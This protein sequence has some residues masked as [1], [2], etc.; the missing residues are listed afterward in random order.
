MEE[1]VTILLLV[2][3]NENNFNIHDIHFLCRRLCRCRYVVE[4]EGKFW[5]KMW[6]CL[7]YMEKE[8]FH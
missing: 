8:K 3:N 5:G 2:D 4:W 1:L 7:D 6:K